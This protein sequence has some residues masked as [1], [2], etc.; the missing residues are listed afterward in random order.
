M[1]LPNLFIAGFPK[2]G[3]T[4]TAWK[5]HKLEAARLPDI[6]IEEATPWD[7]CQKEPAIM[8]REEREAIDL[9]ERF[10]GGE[11]Y[12]LDAT[13]SYIHHE[14]ALKKIGELDAKVV[15]IMRHPVARVISWWNHHQRELIEGDLRS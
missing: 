10:Y 9:C 2:C 8:Q 5:L 15:I 7:S 12:R 1:K 3:T 14:S 11:Q 13:A 6:E 4:Y